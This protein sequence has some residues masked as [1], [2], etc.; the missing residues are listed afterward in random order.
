MMDIFIRVLLAVLWAFCSV[1]QLIGIED[2]DWGKISIVDKV[3]IIIL[4]VIFGPCIMISNVI[5][6]LVMRRTED[7]PKAE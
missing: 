3:I 1:Q 7:G 6:E 5:L 2:I 4:F